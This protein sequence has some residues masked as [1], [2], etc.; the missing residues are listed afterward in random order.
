MIWPLRRAM[1]IAPD[2]PAV[3]FEGVELTYAPTARSPTPS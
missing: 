2:R 1:L 3:A